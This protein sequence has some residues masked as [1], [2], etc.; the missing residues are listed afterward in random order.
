LYIV[1]LDRSIGLGNIGSHFEL[2]PQARDEQ[3]V[4]KQH[5]EGEISSKL[6]SSLDRALDDYGSSVKQVVYWNF[7]TTF[8]YGRES[9]FSHPEEFV[10]TLES[11]FGSGVGIVE[12]R[13]SSEIRSAQGLDDDSDSLVNLLKAAR[14]A[15]YGINL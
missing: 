13:I 14:R 9:V 10:K 2:S 15:S 3:H 5:R 4:A 8:G 11:I 1:P 7:E 6:V 12:K